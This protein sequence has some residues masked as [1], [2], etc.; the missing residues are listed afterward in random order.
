MSS[1]VVRRVFTRRHVRSGGR[2]VACE[3]AFRRSIP[4][5]FPRNV[6]TSGSHCTLGSQ[7]RCIRGV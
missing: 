7:V 6:S 5:A 1:T 3:M 2:D 4:R